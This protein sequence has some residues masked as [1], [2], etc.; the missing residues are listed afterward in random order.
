MVDYNQFLIMWCEE[1]LEGI[2]Q[3]DIQAQKRMLY[4]K[5]KQPVEEQDI[6][7]ESEEYITSVG[8]TFNM[9]I[10]RAR[11]NNH[12]HYEIYT[13]TTSLDL[14]KERINDLFESSPQIIVDLIRE[15]G[16]RHFGHAEKR[17]TKRRII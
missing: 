16:I 13:L 6:K 8:Q 1:G 9:M 15:K 14:S 2:V 7:T 17:K 10:L 11:M 3:I 5:L 4:E 12:R